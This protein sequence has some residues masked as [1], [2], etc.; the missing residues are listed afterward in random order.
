VAFF[1]LAALLGLAVWPCRG[2]AQDDAKSRAEAKLAETRQLLE[3]Q[4]NEAALATLQEAQALYPSPKLHFNF[5]A[6]YQR[7]GRDVEAIEAFERYLEEV[8]KA[9]LEAEARLAVRDLKR[10]LG[11]L[12]VRCDTPEAEILIDMEPRG[13]LPRAPPAATSGSSVLES[14]L[15]Y[16]TAGTTRSWFAKTPSR[17]VTG[18]SSPSCRAKPVSS[19]LG[20]VCLSMPRRPRARA[21]TA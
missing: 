21:S 10:R 13:N 1:T 2:M 14:R 3:K 20:S 19:R 11:A 5:G 18:R 4:E 16:L 7:L 6:V 17:A 9:Q 12:L 15:F 8:E